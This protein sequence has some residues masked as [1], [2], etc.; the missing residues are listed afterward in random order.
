MSQQLKSFCGV[1][2][3]I[4]PGKCNTHEW[5]HIR[6]QSSKICRECTSDSFNNYLVLL[7]QTLGGITPG[8]CNCSEWHSIRHKCNALLTQFSKRDTYEIF[9]DLLLHLTAIYP[10]KCNCS[11]WSTIRSSATGTLAAM[12]LVIQQNKENEL[13]KQVEEQKEKLKSSLIQQKD[14]LESRKQSIIT[15]ELNPLNTQ[16]AQMENKISAEEKSIE[17]MTLERNDKTKK[18]II[19]VGKTGHGKSTFVNRLS[20]DI[21]LMARNGPCQ[22]SIGYRSCTQ[23]LQKVTN[24]KLCII[25]CPGWAD[26]GGADR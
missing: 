25:D 23:S 14:R 4:H 18:I 13:K 24:G 3:N 5:S 15:Q 20:G 22:T 19:C 6:G 2:S 26:A 21:S 1:L 8:S 17:G 12:A 9:K 11:E 16:K 10:G 7:T